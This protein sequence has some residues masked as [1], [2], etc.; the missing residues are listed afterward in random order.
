MPDSRFSVYGYRW[1][2]LIVF[3]LT[4]VAI[5]ML[6]I[7]Y[8]PIT[9]PAAQYYGVGDLQ[10]GLLSMTFMI[11]FI[12]LSIPVAWMV[13]TYGFRVA[14]SIGV[15]LMA[16]FGVLRGLAG[17][18][19]PEALACTAGLAVAQPFLMNSWTKLPANW[20]PVRERAT[21]V[22][23][24]VL[25]NLV[26]TAL[27]LALSPSLA[28]RMPISN[29]QLI[30]GVAATGC[31]L[32]FIVL[33]REHPPTPPASD[34]MQV[35]A[36]MFDGLKHALRV[37]P[38]WVYLLV[39]F[40]GM[41]VFNGIS[42][43]VES[44]VRPRGFTPGQAGQTGAVMLIGGI[45]GALIIPALSDRQQKRQRYLMLG[46]LLGIPG[47]AGLAFAASYGL[48]LAS[49]FVLGFFMVST[50]PVGMQYAAEITHPTPEGT[51]AG[52]IQLCGQASVVFVFVMDATK[53]ANGSFTPSLLLAM[54]LMAVAALAITQLKDSLATAPRPAPVPAGA[55]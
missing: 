7:S 4:N 22:G 44:I 48:L 30:Y 1:V 29:V 25:S 47:L 17:H 40:I 10:I 53:S 38:F 43:W 50:G 9:G 21:A 23:L 34:E 49:A 19:Y 31:A 36:L 11:V 12:P 42:T 2:V 33:A 24:V 55:D 54:G 39:W 52:L 35:R 41:G 18:N 27:G 3:M 5:Q 45:L 16:V 15:V 26:G 28:L 32:L 8:A 6:W 37:K 14:V 51:S 20:F 46:V 13:D